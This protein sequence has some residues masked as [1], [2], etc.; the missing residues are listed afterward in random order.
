MGH[1][2]NDAVSGSEKYASTGTKSLLRAKYIAAI[3]VEPPRSRTIAQL[4][5][6]I[7]AATS[8]RVYDFSDQDQAQSMHAMI[9]AAEPG[10]TTSLYKPLSHKRGHVEVKA[11]IRQHERLRCYAQTIRFLFGGTTK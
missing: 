11:T 3:G 9:L 2:I 1:H 10:T 8:T 5:G 4:A 6:D 7:A